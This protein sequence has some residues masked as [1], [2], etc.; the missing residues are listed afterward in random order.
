MHAVIRQRSEEDAAEVLQRNIRLTVE[1]I[2]QQVDR[3]V[4]PEPDL[5][6][7]EQREFEALVQRLPL[8]GGND[9]RR[10][11]L[12][13]VCT[14]RL[15]IYRRVAIVDVRR[16][17]VRRD[18][19]VA[20]ELVVGADVIAHRRF[21]TELRSRVERLFGH[22]GGGVDQSFVGCH[23]RAARGGTDAEVRGGPPRQT[24]A[25]V[26]ALAHVGRVREVGAE[27]KLQLRCEQ[28]AAAQTFR[29]ANDLEV[30]RRRRVERIGAA[31]RHARRIPTV[32]V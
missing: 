14:A 25:R 27:L 16:I 10:V 8:R 29:R 11:R 30:L 6:L 18:E 1:V 20:A 13:V 22:V 9:L 23:V 31:L 19:A 24:A 4:V 5:R 3:R 17:V 26:E 2:A 21:R 32:G 12:S 7:V 15:Y 28:A